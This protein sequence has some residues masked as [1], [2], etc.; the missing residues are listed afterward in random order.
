M[1][2]EKASTKCPNCGA[3]RLLDREGYVAEC[4]V[5][6]DDEYNIYEIARKVK[7]LFGLN[8]SNNEG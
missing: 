5:C 3:Y 7:E 1:G 2:E 8:P 4:K 6:G